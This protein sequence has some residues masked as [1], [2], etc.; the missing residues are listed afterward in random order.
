MTVDRRLPSAHSS[1]AA[2]T[3]V[4]LA[5]THTFCGMPAVSDRATLGSG[6]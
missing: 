2:A 1:A 5:T 6:G 3:G 4:M